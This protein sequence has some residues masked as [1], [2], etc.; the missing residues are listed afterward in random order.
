MGTSGGNPTMNVY[1]SGVLGWFLL[2]FYGIYIAWFIFELF[3]G[4]HE[5]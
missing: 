4:S 2:T 3:G 5:N 1:I